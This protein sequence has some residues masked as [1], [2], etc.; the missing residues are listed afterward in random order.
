MKSLKHVS[1][2]SL[3][4]PFFILLKAAADK[5]NA[6]PACAYTL[7]C[8]QYRKFAHLPLAPPDPTFAEISGL[9][10]SLPCHKA[11]ATGSHHG[12]KG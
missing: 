4:S 11:D 10:P 12:S 6:N 2:K 3:S 9:P 7:Q 1:G 8:V 5:E